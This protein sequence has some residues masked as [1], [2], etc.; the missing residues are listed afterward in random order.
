MNSNSIRMKKQVT[1]IAFFSLSMN[2]N[3]CAE[4]EKVKS[5]KPNF[6]L[7]IA[8]DLGYA[9]L[10]FQG[11]KQFQRQTSTGLQRKELFFQMVMCPH[12]FAVHRV[13]VL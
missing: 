12:Q 8:D 1:L 9:D 13:L 6:V 2:Y 3:L 7:I 5:E 4:F 10:G 11:S